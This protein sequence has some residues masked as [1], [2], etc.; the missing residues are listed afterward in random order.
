MTMARFAGRISVMYYT[1]NVENAEALDTLINK[2]IDEWAKSE[3]DVDGIT[4]DDAHWESV[5][6]ENEDA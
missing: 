1:D 2:L 4:W 6:V 3:N 5:E